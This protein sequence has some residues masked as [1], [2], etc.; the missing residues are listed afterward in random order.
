MLRER[1]NHAWRLAVTGLAFIGFGL[2]GVVLATLVIPLAGWTARDRV[3]ARERGQRIVQWSFRLFATAL[4]GLGIIT[5][6]L[7]GVER[8]AACRGVIVVA[9]HPT[10]I[11][12]VLLIAHVPHAQCVVKHQ[13]FRNPFLKGM[14]RVMGYI[15][16]DLEAEAFVE[17]CR[18]ALD[19]GQNLIIFPEGTRT[20]PGMPLHFRRGFANV[21]TL[22]RRPLLLVSIVCEPVMLTKGAP[23]YRIPPRPGGYRIAV[24]ELIDIE[25]YLRLPSRALGARQLVADLQD[26]FTRRLSDARTGA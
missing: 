15:R 1:L 13:L 18:L 21:A 22:T 24:E 25:P 14:V 20:V 12:V 19:E 6:R 4:Q 23:W 7:S 11:D 8:L 2:G 26:F 10:L 5:L 16:N 9:N 17:A 3:Q